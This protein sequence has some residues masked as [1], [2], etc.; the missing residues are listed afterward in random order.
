MLESVGVDDLPREFQSAMDA[1]MK[2][3]RSKYRFSGSD[4]V[5]WLVRVGAAATRTRAVEVGTRLMNTGLFRAIGN[6][7]SSKDASIQHGAPALADKSTEYY[8]FENGDEVNRPSGSFV[9]RVSNSSLGGTSSHSPQGST[10]LAPLN[11]KAA[12][13]RS[14]IGNRTGS[15]VLTSISSQPSPTSSSRGT[16]TPTH[17]I[18]GTASSTAS[19][20]ISQPY[21]VYILGADRSGKTSVWSALTG[22]RP[23]NA[24]VKAPFDRPW[25]HVQL[26]RTTIHMDHED[27]PHQQVTLSVWDFD[28]HQNKKHQP[29]PGISSLPYFVHRAYINRFHR[30]SALVVFD[31]NSLDLV[32]LDYWVASIAQHQPYAPIIIVGTHS[33]TV[34]AKT[35]SKIKLFVSKRYAKVKNVRGYITI[36]T[37]SS[38]DIDKLRAL[39]LQHSLPALTAQMKRERPKLSLDPSMEHGIE[40]VSQQLNNLRLN[41]GTFVPLADIRLDLL[42]NG[43]PEDQVEAALHYLAA[44][45]SFIRLP[46]TLDQFTGLY[47]KPE[48]DIKHWAILD[49]DYPFKLQYALNAAPPMLKMRGGLESRG[50]AS[51][52][53]ARPLGVYVPH[54]ARC[55]LHGFIA[56]QHRHA[57]ER[58]RERSGRR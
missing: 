54:D 26:D 24:S 21:S 42:D 4:A 33:D 35:K 10:T 47:G 18:S 3:K 19:P 58:H 5:D 41:G 12:T 6:P 22:K 20:Y 1:R 43:I 50:R 28:T 13:S 11:L 49:F 15:G 36:S 32:E 46:D 38:A 53:H 8:T 7:T 17:P 57:R 44:N 56:D 40:L 14:A 51:R 45:N 25:N 34:S 29:V 27:F 37:K 39:L 23:G 2:D 31:V 30:A 55:V 52:I 48:C 16:P 9:S